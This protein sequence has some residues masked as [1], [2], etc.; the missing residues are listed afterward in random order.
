MSL[1]LHTEIR[2]NRSR[3]VMK[4][5]EDRTEKKNITNYSNEKTKHWMYG[6]SAV[7]DETWPYCDWN[8]W[9]NDNICYKETKPVASYVFLSFF[10]HWHPLIHI[11]GMRRLSITGARIVVNLIKISFVRVYY[12]SMACCSSRT[13]YKHKKIVDKTKYYK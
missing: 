5:S 7:N 4:G 8:E 12:I 11:W 9:T 10:S 1:Q 6:L 3:I 13:K 2:W